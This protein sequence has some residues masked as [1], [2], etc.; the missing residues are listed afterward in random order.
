VLMGAAGRLTIQRMA[1]T[2]S[3]LGQ[4]MFNCCIEDYAREFALGVNPGSVILGTFDE[5]RYN[6]DYAKFLEHVDTPEKLM[7]VAAALG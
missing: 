2:S 6:A 5:E 1:H 4:A 7:T 3:G